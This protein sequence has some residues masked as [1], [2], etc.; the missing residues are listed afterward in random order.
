MNQIRTTIKRNQPILLSGIPR[1][2]A[3]L[4][5]THQKVQLLNNIFYRTGAGYSGECNVDSY[6]ERTHFPYLTKVFSDVHLRI[7][8]NFTFQID[9]LIITERYVLIV[10]VKNLKDS[11]RFVQ[12]PPH[13]EQVIETGDVTIIDCPVYQIET[14]KSNLDEWFRQRGIS[15]KTLG[16][17]VLANQ[18]TNVKDA[19][20]DF[21]IIYKKQL[22]LYLQNLQ[23]VETVLSTVQF[24]DITKRILSEQQQFNPFPLCSYYRIDPKDLRTGLLCHYCNDNLLRKTRETWYCPRCGK[25]AT[26]PY[27][28]A[29]HDW[30]ILVKNSINN[31]E[32][33]NFLRLKDKH[34]AYY[35]LKKSP[36]VK[37]GN[38]SATFYTAGVKR[39]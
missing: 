10:E 37:K 22:P 5:P 20:H 33:R 21:T 28:K 11:I 23:P 13:L 25:D 3:R 29:I 12:N 9:T 38:S 19:P 39:I 1:L 35:A 26:D 30:L 4:S 24:H 2:I 32:C 34:A 14:N 36:L 8:P 7:S 27:N 18:N 31:E 16:I 6:I 15:L 17:L